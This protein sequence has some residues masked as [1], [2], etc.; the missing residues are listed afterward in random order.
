VDYPIQI[1]SETQAKQPQPPKGYNFSM[2]F[3]I[4]SIEI[5]YLISNESDPLGE[6]LNR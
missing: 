5:Y 4:S 2:N 3:V 1:T 6:Q